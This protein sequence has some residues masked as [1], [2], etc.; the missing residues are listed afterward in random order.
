MPKVE[1]RARISFSSTSLGVL[2]LIDLYWQHRTP[3]WAFEKRSD[4]TVIRR[5]INLSEIEGVGRDAQGQGS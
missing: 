1:D 4:V 3:F 2:C 5:K